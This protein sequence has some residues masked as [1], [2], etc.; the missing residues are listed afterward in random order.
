MVM[1]VPEHTPHEDGRS[2]WSV[3]LRKFSVR[4]VD[5]ALAVLVTAAGLIVF[6][7]AGIG[8]NSRAGFL[9]LQNIEQRSLDMR[10]AARGERAHD[11]R[12]VIVGIDEKTLQNVGAFPLPRTAYATLVDRL[13]A[14]G[15]S[16]IAFD[17][18]FPTP[19]SNSAQQALSQLQHELGSTAPASV[20]KKI[21][22][23]EAASD[24]DAVFAAALR[25][26]GRVVLGHLFLDR[27]RANS[28]EAKR[29][30]EYFNIIW[31]K[32]F[33][34]VLK[35][36]SRDHDFDM[37]R[38]WVENGGSVYPGAEANLAQLADAAASYGFFNTNPDPDGTLRRALFIVRYKDQD[39][40]PSLD[41]QTV[42]EYEKI[43]DQ[44][45][46]AY[47]SED[48]L[49]RIQLGRHDLRPWHD[50]TALINY[51]GPYHTYKH[52]SMWNVLNG[53][54]PAETFKDK[55]V[56]VGGTAL[57]IGDLRNTPFQKR[58]AGY[59]GVE[60]HANII[61]NLLHSDEKGRS[62]LTRGLHE[63]LIDAGFIML[64][65]LAFGF[66]FS[67]TK[68]LY[69]TISLFVTLVAFGW[70]IYFT[71]A[72]WG[73]W[74][75]CVVPAGTLVVNYA[76]ITSFR[77]IF[78]EGEKRK[79]RKT[80]SQYLSPG[81][82]ALIEKDPQKY[83]RPG[84]ETKELTVMFSDIRGFTSL[85]EG[86]TADELVL[87]LNEY[88]GEMTDV[89]FRNLGTLDKYIGD[90]IMAF[91]GSPYP[92]TDHAFCACTCALQMT[93]TL[94]KLNA[95]WQAQGR[96][97]ISIGVGLNTGPVNVG[98]MGSAKRLAWTVMGDNVNLASRLEGMTK[99]YHARVVI[100]E[101]TYRQVADQFVCRDLDKIRVKGK[102]QPVTI[103]ELLDV[104]AEK[105]KYEPL[106]SSFDHAMQAYHEQ[107]WQEAAARLGEI[108]TRFPDDGPAQVFLERVLEFIENAPEPDWD[109]VYVMKT[110]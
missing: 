70:F 51:T 75:S 88:L 48:G 80:F 7:F 13:R 56:L 4:H 78:E 108:L 76:V 25:Q 94:E 110:K 85:S 95:R 66:W 71:F 109:G 9:F 23:L 98:N 61:D 43:P 20:K 39:F 104:A 38:A 73:L 100:S 30:E 49:E 84:G 45:V 54:V 65:G 101:G 37:G 99:E 97:Q 3:W 53:A 67:R 12:I 19:E 50:G 11:E 81:V 8:G 42:R 60:V 86:L 41:L 74:L 92:Q 44:E 83:I 107:N 52:Y 5:L 79:I 55:I 89:I 21:K 59:M 32:A 69:S 77:M 27:E 18:T 63:E 57:G 105:K 26:S 64:F 46:A 10:F 33:P 36:K 28:V 24:Y 106:L 14:G 90:A 68:P 1:T 29:A 34:Q 72:H 31:A 16:V 40:F 82:I 58:D 17:V 102:Q 62:F 47:I 87:L 6:A 96:K 2:G 35:V 93:Q 103:Y 15:A 22:E 91:W